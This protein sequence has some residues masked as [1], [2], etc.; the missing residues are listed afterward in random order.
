M[1]PITQGS[2][3]RGM[4]RDVSWESDTLTYV[5]DVVARK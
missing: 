2:V 4:A 1:P 5:R 3:A